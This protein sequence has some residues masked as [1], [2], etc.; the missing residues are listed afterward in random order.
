[1]WNFAVPNAEHDV[2]LRWASAQADILSESLPPRQT[3]WP[4]CP[5]AILYLPHG[6]QM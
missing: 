3:L 1:M 6:T 4:S 2:S 5:P